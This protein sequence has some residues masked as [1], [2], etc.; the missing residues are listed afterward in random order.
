MDIEVA[1][2]KVINYVTFRPSNK[3]SQMLI[4]TGKKSHE[5]RYRATFNEPVSGT[6]QKD[7]RF[8]AND[9]VLVMESIG[10]S[11]AS[12]DIALSISIRTYL[13]LKSN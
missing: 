8:L 13:R 5:G 11:K 3:M 2:K 12:T 4:D 7:I 9:K 10:L 6:F 1:A